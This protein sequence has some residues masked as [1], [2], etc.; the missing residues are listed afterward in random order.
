MGLTGGLIA[1]VAIFLPGPLVSVGILPF[2][3]QLRAN[4]RLGA[5]IFRA[6]AAVVGIHC[7][8]LYDL[9]W[10]T[11]VESWRDVALIALCLAALM[12]WRAA[13]VTA[14][15]VLASVAITAV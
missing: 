7:W 8:A 5:T 3:T 10:T 12:R 15:L 4:V 1:L 11:A 6:N 14:G 13:P 2:R 9:L